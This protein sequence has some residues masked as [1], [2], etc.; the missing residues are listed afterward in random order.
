MWFYATLNKQCD[1]S[2]VEP[3]R[4]QYRRYSHS[5][6]CRKRG[7]AVRVNLIVLTTLS[8]SGTYVLFSQTGVQHPAV[9]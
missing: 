9:E 8:T 2:R 4:V 3:Y 7:G 1:E 6:G 5:T